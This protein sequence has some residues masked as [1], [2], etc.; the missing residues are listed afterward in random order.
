VKKV[1]EPLFQGAALSPSS[2]SRMVKTLREH[3]QQ[4]R[5]RR[6]D[7]LKIGY[8]YLDAMNVSVRVVSRVVKAPVFSAVGVT[9]EGE[10]VLLMLE[11]I[12]SENEQACA[13]AIG[14]LC[15]RGLKAPKM[16]IIDGGKGLRNA[17]LQTWPGIDIQRCLVHKMW[18]LGCK[19]PKH[20][21]NEVL[22]DFRKVMYASD[23]S[24]ARRAYQEMLE[25]WEGR[26]PKVASSLREGGEE[27]FTFFKYPRSQWRSLR[28]T[29]ILERL[30]EEFRRRIKTQCSLPN[31]EAVLYLLFGLVAT[32]F[33][34]LRKIEGWEEMPKLLNADLK[35]CA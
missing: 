3:F 26:Y 2:V 17:V 35:S 32:G 5:H 7:D 20:L 24:S 29:N 25:K 6:L 27:M 34:K 21:R 9:V 1:F 18:N 11:C 12:S 8:L 16:A 15:A 28:T 13:A 22:R 19:V 30:N 10:K 23:Q 33:V 4:W 31:E 14:D